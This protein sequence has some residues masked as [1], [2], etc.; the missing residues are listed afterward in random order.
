MTTT[1]NQPDS[2]AEAFEAAAEDNRHPWV[3]CG[4][5]IGTA[6]GWDQ[7][8]AFAMQLYDLRPAEGLSIPPGDYTICFESGKIEGGW[9]AASGEATISIDLIDAIKDL[10]V[11]RIDELQNCPTYDGRT[12][13][14]ET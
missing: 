4:R 6:T 11:S 1:N 14:E 8:D 3:V 12:P 13:G 5:A 7:A 2:L 10:P 9:D